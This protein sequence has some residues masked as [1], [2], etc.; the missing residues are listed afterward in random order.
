MH[1]VDM[2]YVMFCRLALGTIFKTS[3][4]SPRFHAMPRRHLKA[5]VFSYSATISACEKLGHWQ[6]ALSLLPGRNVVHQQMGH[7]ECGAQWSKPASKARVCS[8]FRRSPVVFGLQPTA[9]AEVEP[10]DH[11][12]RAA[13]MRFC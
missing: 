9:M 8:W 6:Q 5:N 13:A 2:F 11:K 4:T 1:A 3:K 10:R 12:S 7:I